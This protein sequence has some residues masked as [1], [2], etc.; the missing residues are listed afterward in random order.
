[1]ERVIRYVL[2][3]NATVKALIGTRCGPWAAMQD[4]SLPFV[5]Y[6]RVAT[7]HV[8][9]T[10]GCSGQAMALVQV[11]CW[12]STYAGAKTL[13][14]G[15]RKALQDYAGTVGTKTITAMK[16]EGESD[17]M[18]LEIEGGESFRFGVQF[19]FAVWHDVTKPS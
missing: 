3:E 1:V 4:K 10:D 15:V 9:S 12:A 6:Y 17:V 18:E 16:L 11:N 8:H 2:V 13:S 5:T 7:D 19:E 14:D